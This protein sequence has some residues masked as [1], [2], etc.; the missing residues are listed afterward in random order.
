MRPPKFVVLNFDTKSPSNPVILRCVVDSFPRSRISWYRYGQ[1][2][3]EGSSF[4]LGNI[5]T[6]EQQG[7]YSYRIETDGFEPITDDFIIY[8][9]GN[10][11]F[12]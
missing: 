1:K 2:L 7:L 12:C 9:K 11:R 3:V 5:T 4:N 10:S 8:I 6:R